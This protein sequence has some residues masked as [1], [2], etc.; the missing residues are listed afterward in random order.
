VT[1]DADWRAIHVGPTKTDC[2][3]W[4]RGFSLGLMLVEAEALDAGW[5][6]ACS[7]AAVEVQQAAELLPVPSDDSIPW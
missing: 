2:D 7:L 4:Q 3:D 6:E 5:N 1:A